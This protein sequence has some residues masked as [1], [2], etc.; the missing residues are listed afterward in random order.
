MISIAELAP[1][2]KSKMNIYRIFSEEGQM[3][4]PSFD[5]CTM[6]FIRDIVNGKKKVTTLL[7]H[8]YQ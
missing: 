4:L 1:Y 3:Y 5:E 2:M 7:D 8:N 6:Q